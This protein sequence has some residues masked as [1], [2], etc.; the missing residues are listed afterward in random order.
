MIENDLTEDQATFVLHTEA[1]WEA[2]SIGNAKS[3]NAESVLADEVAGRWT[4]AGKM[5]DF[6]LPLLAHTSPAVRCAAATL[7]LK[8]GSH[9][10]AIAVLE[11]LKTEPVGLI[12]S[13][14]EL[15]LMLHRKKN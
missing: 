4:D 3:A 15:Q 12:G 9:P 5:H 13:A 14:A 11:R 10:K 1:Y 8:R 2:I 7:L 6:V